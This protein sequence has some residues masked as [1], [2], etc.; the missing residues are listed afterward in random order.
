MNGSSAESE[1]DW[2]LV[3][4]PFRKD[5]DYVATSLREQKIEVKAA[6][7]DDDLA[8]Y[9]ALSPGIVVITHEALNPEV[10]ARVAEHLATQPSWSELPI[11]VLLERAAPITKIS[12]Q[13]QRS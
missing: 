4:A 11:I 5:A 8:G 9:F 7:A 12:A 10:I 2:V 1:L 13:L 3:I 6:K